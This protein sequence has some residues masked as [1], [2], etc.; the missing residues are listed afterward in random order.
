MRQDSWCVG[1][2]GFG[3]RIENG[4]DRA[5]TIAELYE[6]WRIPD[7]LTELLHDKVWCED[8]QDAVIMADPARV[9]LR[10]KPPYRSDV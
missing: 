5:G 10:P 7:R 6:G 2:A 8:T 9:S 4:P 3:L 1:G